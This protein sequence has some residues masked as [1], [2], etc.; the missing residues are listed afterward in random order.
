MILKCQSLYQK[1]TFPVWYWL[2]VEISLRGYS[3]PVSLTM[4]V[5]AEP[6]SC[7]FLSLIVDKSNKYS[8]MKLLPTLLVAT[9]MTTT[10]GHKGHDSLQ[11]YRYN[12]LY[13]S[14]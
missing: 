13:I 9:I 2:V 7:L 14:H 8:L 1:S 3:I 11:I 10:M 4:S 5:D 12:T 6:T